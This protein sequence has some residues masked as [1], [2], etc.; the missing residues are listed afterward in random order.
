MKNTKH[1]TKSNLLNMSLQSVTDIT[2]KLVQKLYIHMNIK[3][4][5]NAV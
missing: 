3:K 2:Y 5:T 4:N 1:R